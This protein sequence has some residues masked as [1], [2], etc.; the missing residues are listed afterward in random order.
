MPG[1][2]PKLTKAD[3]LRK[4]MEVANV[5]NETALEVYGELFKEIKTALV[6][7]RVV[8]LRGFGTF[9]VKTRKGRQKARNPRTG[10]PVQVS[11]HGVVVFRPGK[12]L[13]A[14]AWNVV[15]QS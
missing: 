3:L 15:D 11:N 2:K 13:R 4:I 8:E 5:D 9:A 10:E 1:K 12:E 14:Q 7:G 6:K